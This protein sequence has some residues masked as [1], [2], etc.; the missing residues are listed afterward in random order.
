MQP[1]TWWVCIEPEINKHPPHHKS[2]YIDVIYQMKWKDKKRVL[3]RHT[4]VNGKSFSYWLQ[5]YKQTFIYINSENLL[6]ENHRD[7]RKNRK[8]YIAVISTLKDK[9]HFNEHIKR[10]ADRLKKEGMNKEKNKRRRRR[11]WN[12]NKLTEKMPIW[13]FEYFC[14]EILLFS[15][16]TLYSFWWSLE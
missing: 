10:P 1:S 15:C 8:S 7:H 11:L 5:L 3:D 4:C 9:N 12:N 16:G 13:A 6:K 14:K 2:L